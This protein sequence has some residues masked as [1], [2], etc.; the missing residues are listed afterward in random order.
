MSQLQ[1]L[2]AFQLIHFLPCLDI[3]QC[4]SISIRVAQCLGEFVL[5]KESQ[6]A[7][8]LLSSTSMESLNGQKGK[9]NSQNK[10]F[11]NF[12][13]TLDAEASF[14]IL[15]CNMNTVDIMKMNAATT[16]NYSL[17]L[18]LYWCCACSWVMY[19]PKTHICAYC[20]ASGVHVYEGRT[21]SHLY[22]MSV[23]HL[24]LM[25]VYICV[26]TWQ[27]EWLAPACI[28]AVVYWS[29]ASSPSLCRP[30]AAL[31]TPQGGS[32]LPW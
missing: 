11:P 5:N 18:A 23:C 19:A 15:M 2:L 10:M 9:R 24:V 13:S 21:K 1:P 6:C 31:H 7:G 28:L 16:F 25:F 32:L 29:M 20:C 30:L 14:W 17:P 8:Q 27:G 3:Q 4:V 12:H 26:G 22:C